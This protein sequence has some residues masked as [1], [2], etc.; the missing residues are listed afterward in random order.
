MKRT[1]VGLL[2]VCLLASL[3]CSGGSDPV[4]PKLTDDQIKEAMKQGKEQH[5]RERGN[6][7]PGM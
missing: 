2:L 6:R 7:R 3:G 1:C 4:Q 5:S